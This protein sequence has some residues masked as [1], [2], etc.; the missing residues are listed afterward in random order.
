MKS[1]RFR[2]SRTG[3]IVTSVLIS[4]IQHFNEYN[5]P[6]EAG[7]F[8]KPPNHYEEKQ[9]ARRQRYL[10]LADSNDAKS[11]SACQ[12]S[13]NAVDGI[14]FGQPILVGHHSEKR[15]RAALNRSDNAMRRSIEAD[16]KAAYYRG[17]AAG[18]G[19]AGISADDPEAVTKLQ[20]KID[21]AE[22]D[23]VLM[24][25][26]NKAIRAN[27]TAAGQ[28]AALI[29]LGSTETQAR[30]LIEPDFCGRVGFA[31]YVLTNNNANIRRMKQ[32]IEQLKEAPTESSES[33]H[34]DVTL[35][36]NV[37]ENRI[38][39]IFPGKPSDAIRTILKRHGFRWSRYNGAW[40]RHLNGAG[41]YAA[42]TVLTRIKEKP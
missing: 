25:K 31:G 28:I 42:N 22:R 7:E 20:A 4:E 14:P 23:Q 27:K 29:E 13:R 9:E 18:V 21:R 40:Q 30:A 36:E 41:R 3:E 19:K 6:T 38:Q 37:D 2:D 24:K 34:G 33:Q 39:L 26:C 1:Q 5:G 17:K 16:D 8:D 15:H 35:V 10:D 11:A 12:A 32:R